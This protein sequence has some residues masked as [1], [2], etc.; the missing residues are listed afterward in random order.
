M[1]KLILA[2]LLATLFLSCTAEENAVQSTDCDGCVVVIQV[3]LTSNSNGVWEDTSTV[4]ES[5]FPCFMHGH[6]FPYYDRIGIYYYRR[7]VKCY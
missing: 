3:S 5:D 7:Y 1:K 6:A 2:V 4:Y